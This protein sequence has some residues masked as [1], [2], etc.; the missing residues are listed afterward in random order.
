MSGQLTSFLFSVSLV[1]FW[2]CLGFWFQLVATVFFLG[3]SLLVVLPVFSAVCGV[4]AVFCVSVV[5]LGGLFRGAVFVVL[6]PAFFGCFVLGC[7]CLAV[8]FLCFGGFCL[9]SPGLCFGA[10]LVPLLLFFSSGSLPFV[11]Y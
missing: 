2:F 3:C 8:F 4:S 1:G 10:F 6:V 5:L 11:A 9:L 7:P